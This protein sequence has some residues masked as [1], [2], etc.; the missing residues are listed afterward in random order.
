MFVCAVQPLP[1]RP[2]RMTRRVARERWREETP[3]CGTVSLPYVHARPRLPQVIACVMLRVFVLVLCAWASGHVVAASPTF[4]ICTV[5]SAPY[6]VHLS[7]ARVQNWL[8]VYACPDLTFDLVNITDGDNRTCLAVGSAAATL[9]KFTYPDFPAGMDVVESFALGSLA[10]GGYALTGDPKDTSK[11]QRGTLYAALDFAERLG[12][13]FLDSSVTVASKSCP[14]TKARAEPLFANFPASY[15]F[16]PSLEYRQVLGFDFRMHPAF[17]EALRNNDASIELGEMQGAGGVVYATPPGFVHT[18][19][20]LLSDIKAGDVPPPDLFASHNE[21]FW[22]RRSRDPNGTV[23]GQLCW[24][25]A[26][27]VEFVKERVLRYLEAQPD[28]TVISV[29]QN[30]NFNYCNSTEEQ[31]I[32]EKEGALIGPLLNAVNEIAD[33]VAEKF[34]GRRVAV[35]TLAY[36]WTRPTPTSSLQPRPNVI[37]R[38]CSIECNFGAPLSDPSNSKFMTDITKWG[39]KSNRTWIWNYVTDFRAYSMPWP[40]YYTLG[41]NTRFYLD[42][43]V[44]GIFQEAAYQSYGADLAALKNYLMSKLLFDPQNANEAAIIQ[45]FLT[46]YYGQEAAPYFDKYMHLWADSVYDRS[47]YLGES[48]SESSAYLTPELLLE[49]ALLMEKAVE[50]NTKNDPA[51][52]KRLRLAKLPTLYVVLLRWGEVRA[53]AQRHKVTWPYPGCSSLKGCFDEFSSIYKENDMTLLSEGGNNLAWLASQLN[54]TLSFL[55]K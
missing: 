16:T 51:L 42:H 25:N 28:A 4:S 40:D 22:P 36:E 44:R 30:D 24:S 17:A 34:P 53:Y 20:A 14:W 15:A 11:F 47:F 43:G 38:L 26:S 13:R 39:K 37:V 46:L 29:S 54:L 45:E 3:F 31:A 7:A 23:Y 10:S 55:R 18:S 9:L 50:T 12:I 21:W 35:D 2:W 32:Y 6:S 41:P 33:A 5:S 19:Y 1:Q 27:L 8:Q 49:S 52:G 48:V